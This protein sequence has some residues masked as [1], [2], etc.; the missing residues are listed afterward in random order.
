MPKRQEKKEKKLNKVIE[1]NILKNGKQQVPQ[2][3]CKKY[4]KGF[5]NYKFNIKIILI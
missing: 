1:M 3:Q 2:K 4:K 5:K